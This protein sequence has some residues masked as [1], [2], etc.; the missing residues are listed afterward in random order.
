[1][2]VKSMWGNTNTDL[3][4][5]SD[6]TNGII[7]VATALRLGNFETNYTEI[8]ATGDLSFVGSAGF[9]PRR[10]SQSTE[11]ANGTGSTQIDVGEVAI[12]RDSVVDAI[13]LIYNDTLDDDW[14]IKIFFTDLTTFIDDGLFGLDNFGLAMITFLFIFILTGVMSHKYGLTSA[15]GIS[16]FVFSLILF[17]DVGVGLMGTIGSQLLPHAITYFFGLIFVAIYIKEVTK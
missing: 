13:W 1:D 14:S 7:D 9:Y 15:T 16:A 6:G 8:S 10:I 5:S 11:P 3:Q 4:I 17:L 2:N 12:W